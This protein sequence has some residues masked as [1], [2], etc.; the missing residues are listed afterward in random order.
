MEAK[1]IFIYIK[2]I[3]IYIFFS[4]YRAKNKE[5]KIMHKLIQDAQKLCQSS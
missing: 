2:S 4:I 1:G 5:I 3:F